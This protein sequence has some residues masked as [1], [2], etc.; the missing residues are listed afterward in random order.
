[1]DPAAVAVADSAADLAEAVA[2]SAADLAEA[3]VVEAEADVQAV[4]D[5]PAVTVEI[6]AHL[7][8][9]A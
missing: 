6:D 4:A 5:G 3:V 7:L 1:M 9:K 8:S 2:A